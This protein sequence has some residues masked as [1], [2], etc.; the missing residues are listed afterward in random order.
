MDAEELVLS[1][2]AP[3]SG[4][5]NCQSPPLDDAPGTSPVT[6][7]SQQGNRTESQSLLEGIFSSEVAFLEVCL[8][9][10]FQASKN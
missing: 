5:G 7:L 8:E 6:A 3:S 4:D 10:T 1:W 9:I 2:W